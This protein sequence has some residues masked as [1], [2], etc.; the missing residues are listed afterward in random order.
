VSLIGLL[1]CEV[2][3]SPEQKYEKGKALAEL[4]ITEFED[5]LNNVDWV[6]LQNDPE[7]MKRESTELELRA[8]RINQAMYNVFLLMPPGY[9]DD[10]NQWTEEMNQRMEALN[11]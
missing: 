6:A 5:Q 7:A 10:Y 1:G 3:Q 11:Y 8:N 9:E 4:K 2:F